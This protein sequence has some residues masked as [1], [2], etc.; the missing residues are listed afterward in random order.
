MSG[1]VDNAR[2]LLRKADHDIR[3]ADLAIGDEELYDNLCFHA[4]QAAEKSLKAL[5]A[6]RDAPYPWT[7]DIL[8]LV[9]LVLP[10]H[11]ELE[12]MKDRLRGLT[13]Y[14]VGGR[15]GS[16]QAEPS[17]EDARSALDLAKRVYG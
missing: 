2:E 16:R 3:M 1:P 10:F 14:A 9:S 5:L 6:L 4:Q 13:R 11:G 12:A 8:E 17:A 7:H 15:Y